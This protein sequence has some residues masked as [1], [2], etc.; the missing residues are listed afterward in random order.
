MIIG[1][2]KQDDKI[3]FSFIIS[4]DEMESMLKGESLN[5][6]TNNK[7]FEILHFVLK[8]KRSKKWKIK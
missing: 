3:L 2:E 5:K 4:E 6:I 7:D 1:S 8:V